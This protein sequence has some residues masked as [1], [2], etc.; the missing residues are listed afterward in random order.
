MIPQK[1]KDYAGLKKDVVTIGAFDHLEIWD[2]DNYYSYVE[3]NE[4]SEEETADVLAQY[5]L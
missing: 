2:A 3:N 1:L 4:Y 5:G